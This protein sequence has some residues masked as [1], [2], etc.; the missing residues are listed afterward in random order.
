[1]IQAHMPLRFTLLSL[2]LLAP[3]LLY[4]ETSEREDKR[5]QTAMAHF[6]SAPS[7]TTFAAMD[8]GVDAKCSRYPVEQLQGLDKLASHGNRYAAQLLAPQ[9][10]LLDGGELEDA[11]RSLGEFGSR[12][13]QEFMA[14][15]VAGALTDRNI[16]DALTM[17]P[18]DLEDD[19]NAQ[20]AELRKRRAALESLTDQ[21][22]QQRGKAAIVSLE[23]FIGEVE[24]A[25][26][27][28]KAQ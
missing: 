17:L 6:L 10:R 25:Q 15:A 21:G 22:A 1:M 26:S 3:A 16:A 27:A 18:L 28:D 24:R 5:C 12:H 19:F 8:R 4:G 2:C 11:L 9:V 23:K 7:N 13:M 14:P 20:L